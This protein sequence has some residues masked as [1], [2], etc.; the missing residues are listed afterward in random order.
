MAQIEVDL[1]RYLKTVPYVDPVLNQTHFVM[2]IQ[3]DTRQALITSSPVELEKFQRENASKGAY[4]IQA[5][6]NRLTAETFVQAWLR[7]P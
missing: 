4:R 3:G 2:L 5:F 6:P 1:I 7:H